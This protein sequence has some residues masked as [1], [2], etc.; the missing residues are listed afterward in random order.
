[1][2]SDRAEQ[3]RAALVRPIWA[4]PAHLLAL[5]SYKVREYTMSTAGPELCAENNPRRVALGFSVLTGEIIPAGT[6][7]AP[8]PSP[9]AGG[10]GLSS[11]A[12]WFTLF[13]FGPLINT[14]WYVRATGALT[15]TIYEV[16]VE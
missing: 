2:A 13:E 1:M 5:T 11:E 3:L 12:R 16:E 4:D 15:L 8:T 10:F 14:E 7:V 6:T 9:T